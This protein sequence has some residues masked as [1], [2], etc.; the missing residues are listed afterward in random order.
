MRVLVCSN[1]YPPN[2]IGGAELIAHYQAKELVAA[3]HDVEVFAGE[4]KAPGVRHEMRSGTYDGLTVHRVHLDWKDFASNFS[5]F[6]HLRV[7]EHFRNILSRLSPDVVHC[8]NINGLSVTILRI[9]HEFGARVIV[10]L[11]D[12][13]GFCLKNTMMKVEGVACVDHS[14]CAE[15]EP[16]IDDGDERR[17]PI[18]LRRDY[19][20]SA[21]HCVD[22]FVSPSKYLA[23]T[24]E[25]A[26][27]PRGRLHVVW[28][29]VDLKK[30]ASVRPR[31]RDKTLKFSY[32]GHFGRHKGLHTLLDALPK[33]KNP[34]AVR[35]NLVGDGEERPR[36]EEQLRNNGC[37]EMVKFWGKVDNDEIAKAYA[38]TD[39]LVLP[40]IWHENQP[41]SI[42]E[43]MA[44]GIPVIASRMG[45]IPELIEDGVTGLIF[46]AGDPMDLAAKMNRLVANRDLAS[47]LGQNGHARIKD[48]SY[49]HQIGRLLKIYRA[50]STNSAKNCD[51]AGP[52]I[53]CV[54]REVQEISRKAIQLLGSYGKPPGAR[55]VMSEWLTESQLKDAAL[56]WVVDDSTSAADILPLAAHG[57]AFLVPETNDDLLKV[58]ESYRC[59]LYF[60]DEHLAAACVTYLLQSH[61]DRRRL[62]SNAQRFSAC[63]DKPS[64]NEPR[65]GGIL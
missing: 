10:T 20:A 59:G 3:G 46:E 53:V 44:C 35:V 21:L 41:V 61:E 47:S 5:T 29:G 8:H 1:A 43:A 7:E 42:T 4:T 63:A 16:F 19:M 18:Q 39:V 62:G 26:G 14:R 36:Y 32:F 48:N 17:I 55:I 40:S 6:S 60:A 13:W 15:C 33:L 9:A 24:Y 28:N 27:F 45:G 50:G 38:E 2:F 57:L 54:G 65:P 49:A 52:M 30:F 64:E 34:E 23:S 37:S 56:A 51:H 58:C 25:R 12:H 11:H 22:A 31:F